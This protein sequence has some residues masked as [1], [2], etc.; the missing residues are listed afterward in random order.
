[1]DDVITVYLTDSIERDP[2][3]VYAI[4]IAYDYNSFGASAAQK[5]L[6][7]PFSSLQSPYLRF[8]AAEHTSELLRYHV[9]CGEVS[10]A[11]ASSDQ[12]WL[13]SRFNTSGVF[14][15]NQHVGKCGQCSMQELNRTSGDKSLSR[16]QG[17]RC[18]WSYLYRSAL[19]LAHHP[20]AEAVTTKAFVLEGNDCPSCAHYMQGSILEISEGL[21]KAIK[22]AVEQVSL[23]LYPLSHVCDVQWYMLL[24]GRFPYP[25]LFPWDR[26]APLPP[27]IDRE[28]NC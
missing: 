10:S 15:S 9:A 26:V 28:C 2:V 5:C 18:L 8:V 4:A 11:L 25:R 27:R 7:I 1:L 16:R 21:G 13:S 3:G 17:P 19:V 24:R 23:S 12:T 20:T 22:N 14:K 6:N